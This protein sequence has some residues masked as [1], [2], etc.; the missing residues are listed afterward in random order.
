M[1]FQFFEIQFFEKNYEKTMK[2][3]EKTSNFFMKAHFSRFTKKS[4]VFREH[5]GNSILVFLRSLRANQ[6]PTSDFSQK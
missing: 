1:D 3:H 6:N 2:N 4:L 5:I